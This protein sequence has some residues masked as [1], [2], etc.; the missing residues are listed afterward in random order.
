MNSPSHNRSWPK[1]TSNA[2]QTDD[3]ETLQIGVYGLGSAGTALS[4]VLSSLNATVIAADTDGTRVTE[5]N[6]GQ[7]PV[8]DPPIDRLLS[9]S[10]DSGALRATTELPQVADEAAVHLITVDT[11]LRTDDVPDL[12]ALRST[13]RDIATG[14]AP[15]DLVVMAST[16]PPGTTSELVGPLLSA[17]SGLSTDEFGLAIGSLPPSPSL[18]TVRNGDIA[19]GGADEKSR[20]LARSLFSSV[21]HGSVSDVSNLQTAECIS[22]F[23]RTIAELSR[24]LSNE[25]A[26]AAAGESI[27]VPSV[28]DIASERSPHQIPDAGFDSREPVGSGFLCDSLTDQTPI[29]DSLYDAASGFPTLIAETVLEALGEQYTNTVTDDTT[30]LI[31]GIPTPEESSTAA[32]LPATT[33]IRELLQAETRP[34]ICDP[35]ASIP[36]SLTP[37]TVSVSTANQLSPAAVVVLK[38]RPAFDDLDWSGYDE[39]VVIDCCGGC[40][41][42][43]EKT[44]VHR[45]GTH[46]TTRQN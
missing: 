20:R 31:L 13:V 35:T 34:L 26:V 23:E 46:H 18:Q 44:T 10:V 8:T 42:D 2:T 16:V 38:S 29:L 3:A 36:R 32:R 15:G 4:V 43:T 11:G 40:E 5:L 21:T 33:L 12:S 6:H 14:L 17:E 45:L 24:G 37:H 28:I 27:D 7:S 22:A 30:V 19:V 25:L 1:S 39:S 41:L 9:K